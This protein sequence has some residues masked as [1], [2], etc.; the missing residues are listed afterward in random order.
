MIGRQSKTK[1]TICA[2]GGSVHFLAAA[3][4]VERVHVITVQFGPVQLT[5]FT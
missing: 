1:R 3:A 2:V 5:Q 4:S